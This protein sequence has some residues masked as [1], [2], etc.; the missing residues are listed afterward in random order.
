PGLIILLGVETA[1]NVVLDIYRPRLKDQYSRAAFDSRLLGI[2]SEPGEV[3]HTVAGAIDYQF[4]FKVSQTWFYQLLERAIVPLI[5]LASFVIYALS[6]IVV[7]DPQEQAIIERFGN[8]QTAQWEKRLYGPGLVWKMPWPIDIAYKYPTRTIRE[9]YIGYQPKL[10]PDTKLPVVEHQLIWGTTHYQEEYDLIIASPTSDIEPGQGVVPVS[11]VKANV[12]VQYKIKDLYDYMYNHSEP[13]KLLEAICY[14]ELA[15]FAAS[16]KVEVSSP[17]DLQTSILGAGRERAK[18]ILTERIQAEADAQR[19]GIEIVFVGM[20]GIHP[21]VDV[22]K[23]YQRVV[24]AVQEKEAAILNAQTVL[25]RTLGNLAG[26]VGYAE[27][28]YKL[29]VELE[30]TPDDSSQRQQL[31]TQIDN[32]FANAGGDIFKTLAESKSYAFEKA[33]L[34][35]ADSKRFADQMKP[36]LAAKDIYRKNLRL[37][38]FEDEALGNIRKYVFVSDPNDAQV[39]IVD[40]QEKLTP[41]LYDITGL[42]NQEQ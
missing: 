2:I 13:E 12:P 18:Q 37:E 39:F 33:T 38:V 27:Q 25:N 23:D 24:A 4:G 35:E 36:Y 22:A 16:A 26:S 28:L 10:D 17:Q 8:P 32:A 29:A 5:L 41:G 34:S 14:G 42:E 6:T 19:L 1:I 31:V 21:P 40:V 15:K 7:I 9:I 3:L 11:I 20:Q 30:N